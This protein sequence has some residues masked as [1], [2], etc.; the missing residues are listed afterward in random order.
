MLN[1]GPITKTNFSGPQG[2]I[3]FKPKRV[4]L[5]L[6]NLIIIESIQSHLF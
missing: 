1:M 4:Q 5:R 6:I 2:T 3:T